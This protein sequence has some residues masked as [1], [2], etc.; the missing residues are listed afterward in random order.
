M[1]AVCYKLSLMMFEGTDTG[2]S[3]GRDL[4]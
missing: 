4:K 3:C 1:S 2:N